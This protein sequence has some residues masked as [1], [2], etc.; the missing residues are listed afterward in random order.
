[1][2]HNPGRWTLCMCR[3]RKCLDHV[4]LAAQVCASCT[5]HIV[6]THSNHRHHL[7]ST[8]GWPCTWSIRERRQGSISVIA[9]HA[10]LTLQAHVSVPSTVASHK[11]HRPKLPPDCS[12]TPLHCQAS[13][14]RVAVVGG[15]FCI[16]V[17]RRFI[18]ASKASMTT[19]RR[20][21]KFTAVASTVPS[22]TGVRLFRKHSR[23]R[24]QNVDEG[25]PGATHTVTSSTACVARRRPPRCVCQ[26]P[27]GLTRV[28]VCENCDGQ[29]LAV[30]NARTI[31]N[32]CRFI[33]V[34]SRRV[35]A[36]RTRTVV[37][38]T[39]ATIVV[40]QTAAIV[41]D[42]LRAVVACGRVGA[43]VILV[44]SGRIPVQHQRAR[45]SW[46]QVFAYPQSP[47][48]VETAIVIVGSIVDTARASCGSTIELSN[49]AVVL[50]EQ[51]R[52]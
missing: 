1:M 10:S 49:D 22:R 50:V 36:A 4:R 43:S 29:I 3:P 25:Q 6:S 34:A 17:A 30:Q 21:R 2:D 16:V 20:I 51:R 40:L 23:C 42:G 39:N 44:E 8:S 52:T 11:N 46:V 13:R 9:H 48:D 28:V 15:R 24:R 5:C 18:R 26:T 27:S 45:T 37:P 12:C 32:R 47:T 33:V 38:T 41:V 19:R 7:I 31:V 35:G 14:S